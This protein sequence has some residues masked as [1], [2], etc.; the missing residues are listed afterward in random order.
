[1]GPSEKVN[2]HPTTHSIGDLRSREWDVICI[3]SGWAGRI[4][5]AR[6]VKAGLKAIVVEEEL[7]GGDCPFWACV[8]SKVL[9]R[10]HEALEEASSVGGARE[11]VNAGGKDVDA[12]ATFARRDAF[13]A[14]WDDTKVLIPMVEAT[15]VALV[16]GRGRLHGVKTVTVTAHDGT[17][18]NITARLAV[19][20]CTG[21]IPVYPSACTGLK[22]A[23]PWTPRDATSSN[24]IPEHLVV[25]GAGAV[26][27][28]MA[29]AY[30]NFGSKVTLVS[31]SAEI[32]PTVDPE[33]G[34][35]VREQ[36]QKRGV[37]VKVGTK[38]VSVRRD[39]PDSVVVELSDGSTVHA[40]E[41]LLA[42]GR[43]GNPQD[44]GLDTVGVKPSAQFIDVD[45][46]LCVSTTEGGKWLYAAGDVNG[47]NL[48]T[49]TSK[50]HAR[51]ASNAILARS[52]GS[53]LEDSLWSNYNATA[54]H[55]ATPQ[56]IFSDPVV[57][58][59]GLTKAAAKAQGL[60][61]REVA[62]SMFSVGYRIHSDTAPDGRAAWLIDEDSTLV[63]ATFVGS[64]AAEIIHAATV[65]IVGR[66]KI[67]QLA[68]AI[69]SFPT[70][71]EVY[72]NLVDAAGM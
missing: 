33:A 64:G 22:Q 25:I 45:E 6:I 8:P 12:K 19:V 15:G 14:G 68:H 28:E 71:S 16:R 60:N 1:M 23:D 11:R 56:V 2:V 62:I 46:S 54:D 39:A 18:A 32:L 49:H 58:Q 57:A 24:T 51:I 31:S 41:I 67:D 65:A 63:G 61:T 70:I 27:T 26:G 34:K 48:L 35:I 37:N 59:V 10:S 36:L 29:V 44:L 53:E 66:M 55:F 47:R 50:Y 5:A 52:K 40:T 7:I 72:L 3:G 17:S 13:V 69:P 9:L 43:T 4:L 42:A 38:V 21:S 30:T 20:L